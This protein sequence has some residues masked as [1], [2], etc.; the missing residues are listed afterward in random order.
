MTEEKRMAPRVNVALKV[1]L[2]EYNRPWYRPMIKARSVDISRYGIG[3]TLRRPIDETGI[4]DLRIYGP[5]FNIINAK[6][7]VMWQ[8]EN[9]DRFYRVGVQFTNIAW[10]KIKR[11]LVRHQKVR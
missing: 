3:L 1:A 5:F 2:S 6:G 9:F 11:L 10:S 4:I 8:R 7:V